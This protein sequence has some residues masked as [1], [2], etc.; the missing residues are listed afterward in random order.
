V[1]FLENA[2]GSDITGA[3]LD[4]TDLLALEIRRF[5]DGAFTA[6]LPASGSIEFGS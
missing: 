4:T 6:E 5:S 3:F 1:F 2:F